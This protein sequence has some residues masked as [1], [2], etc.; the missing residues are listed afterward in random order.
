MSEAGRPE[1]L[2][3]ELAVQARL[4]AGSEH[5]T[6]FFTSKRILVAHG[7]KW[8]SGSMAASSFLGGLGGVVRGLR[9]ERKPQAKPEIEAF[10]ARRILAGDKDNF[11]IAYVEVVNVVITEPD[12]P[13]GL[14]SISMLTG[15]DKLELTSKLG[16]GRVAELFR[17][18]L[19]EKVRIQKSRKLPRT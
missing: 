19:G 14:T 4:S 8:G 2:W 11:S 10:S 15:R 5:L 13:S 17:K 9:R 6:F 7:V 18:G 12:D 3:S 16:V 1:E